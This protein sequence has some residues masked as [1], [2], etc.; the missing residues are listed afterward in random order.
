MHVDAAM[1]QLEETVEG[2]KVHLKTLESH[3]QEMKH[4]LSLKEDSCNCLRDTLS[5]LENERNALQLSNQNFAQK[6][7][8][9]CQEFK[10]LEM[11]LNHLVLQLVELNKE[12]ATISDQVSRLFLSFGAYDKLL[13]QEKFLAIKSAQ[14]KYE[15]LHGQFVHTR[16]ENDAFKLEIEELKHKTM[17][18][19]KAQ[20][21]AMV[22]HAEEC[23]L[24]EDKIRIL[25]TEAE[26]LVSHKK[27]SDK[28]V[29]ELGEKVKDLS[30][31]CSLA[32]T[33]RVCQ[34]CHCHY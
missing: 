14:G 12:S 30:K 9:S 33:Q 20:E 27:E 29:S 22:Q 19:Q 5:N 28:L 18:L 17:E 1:K 24:A 23:H 4:E 2:N 21:F 8:D 34:S 15:Q 25:E 6:I 10:E 7:D 13:Q 3:M 31:A 16:S 11:L 26:V 32:E